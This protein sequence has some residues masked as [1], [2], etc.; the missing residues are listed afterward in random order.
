MRRLIISF[1]PAVPRPTPP[2]DKCFADCLTKWRAK[3]ERYPNRLATAKRCDRTTR[4]DSCAFGL[5]VRSHRVC[6]SFA[7]GHLPIRLVEILESTVAKTP[8]MVG[9]LRPVVLLPVSFVTNVPLSQL[10]AIL[11][12]ELTHVRRHDFSVNLVQT[13]VETLFFYHS[14]IWWLLVAYGSNASIAAMVSWIGRWKIVENTGERSLR[15]S[16]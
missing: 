14:A 4:L 7:D 1:G 16:D 13:L 15:L 2:P 10:E 12:H 8:M 9:Y 5:V 3:H 11:A 6:C